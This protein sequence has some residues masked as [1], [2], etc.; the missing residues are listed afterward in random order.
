MSPKPNNL[1]KDNSRQ[2]YLIWF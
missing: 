1:S 2:L